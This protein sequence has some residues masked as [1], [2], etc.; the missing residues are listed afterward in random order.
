MDFIYNSKFLLRYVYFK[1]F[2]FA[3]KS[4]TE[5]ELRMLIE[6]TWF[7]KPQTCTKEAFHLYKCKTV[8]ARNLYSIRVP[9]SGIR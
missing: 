3:F 2:Y 1:H 8:T 5:I 7:Q 6:T 9:D 4:F